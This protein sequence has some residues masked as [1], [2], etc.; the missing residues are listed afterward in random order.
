M[1]K[2][3]EDKKSSIVLERVYNVPL[4]KE[5]AKAPRWNRAKK[6]TKALKEFL[7]KH[8][9]SEDVKIGKYLNEE[10]WKHGIKN[11]PHHV[12]V[13]A[14]KDSNGRV[15][16][17]LVGAPK[18]QPKKEAKKKAK[19]KKA[20]KAE[21]KEEILEEKEEM[22]KEEQ[23]EKAK[24]TEKEEIKDLQREHVKVHAPKNIPK[25]KV[26]DQHPVTTPMQRR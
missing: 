14:K 4:R 6:A 13:E 9:K 10:L 12:K 1:A 19:P 25:P 18:E 5:F 16:A 15:T 23:Q 20:E 2:K 26:A 3:K 7:A 21:T 11:P 24:E 8:M 17:E 22:A